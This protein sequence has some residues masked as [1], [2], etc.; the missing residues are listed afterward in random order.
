MQSL[1]RAGGP[2]TSDWESCAKPGS[3]VASKGGQLRRFSTVAFL[4]SRR[5]SLKNDAKLRYTFAPLPN[6]SPYEEHALQNCATL[7]RA[8]RS[9]MLYPVELRAPEKSS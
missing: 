2:G 3:A 4:R 8:F 9:Q 1:A 5:I 7:V 6:E